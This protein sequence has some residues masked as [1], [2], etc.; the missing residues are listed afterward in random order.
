MPHPTLRRLI[1]V[2]VLSTGLA[3]AAVAADL[4][5]LGAPARGVS[6]AWVAT[7]AP[8]TVRLDALAGGAATTVEIPLPDGTRALATR[9]GLTT[10]GPADYTWSGDLATG[11]RVI[12]VVRGE[13]LAGILSTDAGN[14][15]I[16]RRANGTH[17][18]ETLDPNAFPP[19]GHAWAGPPA[20]SGATRSASGGPSAQDDGSVIDVL[21]VYSNDA[22][23]AVADIEAEIQLMID[24]TNDVLSN[25]QI[26]PRMNLVAAY[27]T[28]YDATGAAGTELSRLKNKNDNQMDEVHTVRDALSADL[29]SLIVD[30]MDDFCGTAYVMQSVNLGFESKA[31][32]VVKLDCAVGNFSFPHELGHNM[33]S[34]HDRANPSGGAYPYSWGYIHPDANPPDSWRTVMAYPCQSP[35][36]ACPRIPHFSNP[37]VLHNGNATGIP[38]GDPDSA[39]NALSI[40]NTASVVANFRDST[41]CGTDDTDGDGVLDGCDNCLDDPNP[42]QEDQDFD[43]I[44]DLCDNCP[45]VLNPGQEDADDNGIGDACEDSDGDGVPDVQDNCPDDP[46]PGQEDADGDEVGDVCDPNPNNPC[47]SLAFGE[48]STPAGIALLLAPL[49]AIA[50]LRR[51]RRA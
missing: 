39:D 12:L 46:N 8:A 6:E 31:F 26:S 13:T 47:A 48:G 7:R 25:S 20:P 38:D 49:A 28:D 41:A 44:G 4:V 23:A 18:L 1:S 3:T 11:G 37:L 21:V 30:D 9:T 50:W 43:Q 34:R 10:R 16:Q 14:V 27:H 36:P 51:R 29:V 19:E 32:S 5:E 22:Q 24:T 40:S 35:D 45:T 33:G 17:V 42:G 15:R 2:C